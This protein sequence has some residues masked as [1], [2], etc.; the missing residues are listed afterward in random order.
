MN[1]IAIHYAPGGGEA[2]AGAL[3][4][5]LDKTA[6]EVRARLSDPEGGPAVVA[7]YGEIEPAWACA[8]RLRANGISPILLTDDDLE[9]DAR[10]FLVR[11]FEL[12]GQGITATSRRGDTT[13]IVYRDLDL[14]L[15]GVKLDE[16]TE[17]KTTEQRK[18]SLSR[19]VLTQGLMMTKTVRTTD[20]V[21]SV[22]REEFFHLYAPGHPPL[23]F[24]SGA[25]DY[26]SFGHALQPSVQAN[27]TLLVEEMRRALPQVSYN[28]RL[29]NRQSRARILGPGLTDKNL[30]V[31]VSLLAR[32]LRARS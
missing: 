10:R 18:F 27:F 21:T 13:R 32:V 8:G 9:T 19:A 23:V 17:T 4:E 2:L 7:R 1:V 31:A 12:D 15:R 24:R 22:D 26:R 14:F 29:A 11:G 6:Y 5:A 3:A 28:E 16:R 30:D 25:L 20:K